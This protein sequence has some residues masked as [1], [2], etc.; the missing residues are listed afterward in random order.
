MALLFEPARKIR[1]VSNTLRLLRFAFPVSAPAIMAVAYPKALGFITREEFRLSSGNIVLLSKATPT[2]RRWRSN[3]PP[4]TYGN[5]PI[6][7]INGEPLFAELAILRLFQSEG[8]QGVWIDTYRN[9]KRVAVNQYADLPLDKDSLLQRIY[10]IAGTRSG[11][12]DV[13]CWKDDL[14]LF[15]ESKWKGHDRI[16]PTQVRWLTAA[17]E[18]GLPVEVFLI[19]EWSLEENQQ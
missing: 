19:V 17:L 2:F 13:F 5:K 10:K 12:F 14:V 6:V 11:C 7:D 15:A 8:W 3:L 4:D 9:R 1:L 18:N 16:R